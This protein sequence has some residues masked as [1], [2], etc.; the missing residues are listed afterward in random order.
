[1]KPFRL[2]VLSFVLHSAA[3]AFFYFGPAL[4]LGLQF[5]SAWIVTMG[6]ITILA[7]LMA[8]RLQFRVWEFEAG[9][10]IAVG[11]FFFFSYFIDWSVNYETARFSFPVFARY[12]SDSLAESGM[13][14]LSV[15]LGFVGASVLGYVLGRLTRARLRVSHEATTS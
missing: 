10:V 3:L 11:F 8:L 2:F 5:R 14:S 15:P 1:M 4:T 13:M 9:G 7:F 6:L 12:V